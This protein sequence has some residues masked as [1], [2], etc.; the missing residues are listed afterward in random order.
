MEPSNLADFHQRVQVLRD[1]VAPPPPTTL[2]HEEVE[3]F[4]IMINT[5]EAE[6]DHTDLTLCPAPFDSDSGIIGVDGRVGS[7]L[8]GFLFIFGFEKM[9]T[10]EEP[11]S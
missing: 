4:S 3:A 7:L 1:I 9:L 5:T 11:H 6:L 10:F 2:Q 8:F